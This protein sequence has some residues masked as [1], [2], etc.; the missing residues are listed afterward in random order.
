MSAATKRPDSS[1]HA[2]YYS[3]YVD[4]VPEGDIVATLSNQLKDSLTFYRG[5]SEEKAGFR[6]AADKWSIKEVL[7]HVIDGER[8][9][10]YRALRF[11]RNDGTP[12]ESF[13]QDDYV[14]AANSDR[15]SFADLIAEYESVRRASLSLLASFEPD[16]WSKRG[17]ASDN[18]V[19][20]RALAFIIGGH[21]RHHLNVLKE[22]YL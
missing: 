5:I 11:A 2:A 4:L 22:K 1:E 6:Y 18:E 9:F 7:G 14:R 8:V 13:E 19:T 12:L 20:V 3:R 15:R 17:V 10:S 21:E 16:D